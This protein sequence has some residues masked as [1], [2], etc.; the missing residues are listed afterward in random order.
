MA[1]AGI[2]FQGISAAIVYTAIDKISQMILTADDAM[3]AAIDKEING[4]LSSIA[5]RPDAMNANYSDEL[6]RAQGALSGANLEGPDP[7]I[8]IMPMFLDN[9]VGSFFEDYTDK[10]DMLFPGLGAAG[11]DAVEFARRS[12]ASNIGMSYNEFVDQ[13]PIDSAFLLAQR[14]AFAQEREALA[15]AAA[16]GHRFAPG[17]TMDAL[18]RMH[19]N[20]ISTAT[21][22]MKQVYAARLAQERSEKM[23]MAAASIDTSMQ[24]IKKL[25]QQVAEAF[26]LKMR[27]RGLWINDQNQVVDA[28][29]NVYAMNEKFNTALTALM[30]KTA[31]RRFGL[32]FDELATKDRDD[33]I[34]KLKM[35]NANE[36]VDLFGNMV[37]TLMNQ[38][39]GKGAYNGTER[40]ITDWDNILA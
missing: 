11:A 20:S 16:A 36:V 38:V 21:D 25:H 22:T 29:N 13:T 7:D 31:T 28:A 27:A 24:R 3:R 35:A 18:A 39:S 5:G 14:D 26:K 2:G 23:R 17:A 15:A 1:T 6:G 10:L 30:R 9:V 37:T 19:G 32:K 12:L 34:G 40:D 33:F 4:A 8:E